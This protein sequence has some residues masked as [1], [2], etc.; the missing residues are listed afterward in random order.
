MKIGVE[1]S[2]PDAYGRH[3][4]KVVEELD[5]K[6]GAIA[7]RAQYAIAEECRRNLHRV[8]RRTT[9]QRPASVP[10]DDEDLL[11]LMQKG[12]KA[13]PDRRTL[14]MFAAWRTA[15]WNVEINNQATI[16]VAMRAVLT[17]RRLGLV[18][19]AREVEQHLEDVFDLVDAVPDNYFEC[20]QLSERISRDMET[21]PWELRHGHRRPVVYAD[22]HPEDDRWWQEE[23]LPELP[24]HAAKT[25]GARG[26]PGDEDFEVPF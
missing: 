23:K 25:P 12:R 24:P 9:P 10:D 5:N 11:V 16:L 14:A 4:S 15:V 20:V 1:L 17:Y 8:K 6:D 21:L 13:Q 22:E 19:E 2:A 18:A 7:D 3:W 26:E